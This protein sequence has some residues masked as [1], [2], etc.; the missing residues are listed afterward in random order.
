MTRRTVNHPELARRNFGKP[1]VS[2]GIMR[3][4][5]ELC[6]CI[7]EMVERDVARG[8]IEM[9]D[10]ATGNVAEPDLRIACHCEAERSRSNTWTG[11]GHRPGLYS[12]S[13]RIKPPNPSTRG[14]CKPE[15]THGIELDVL[16]SQQATIDGTKWEDAK[17]VL[18][19]IKAPD[20]VCV[21]LHKPDVAACVDR[22]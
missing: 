2:M 22:G 9:T 19:G 4:R 6:I 8:R 14:C 7:S 12:A 16:R 13:F 18:H 15:S 21:L 11:C 10:C 1:D 5:E 20:I 3:H 17:H